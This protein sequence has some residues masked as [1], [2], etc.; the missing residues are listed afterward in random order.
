MLSKNVRIPANKFTISSS[1]GEKFNIPI[2]QVEEAIKKIKEKDLK[3]NLAIIRNGEAKYFQDQDQ[4]IKIPRS[5]RVHNKDI[6]I[7][8]SDSNY[9]VGESFKV[10]GPNIL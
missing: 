2:E 6:K 8:I 9:N 1:L 10:N 5:S 7:D 4:F 3:R